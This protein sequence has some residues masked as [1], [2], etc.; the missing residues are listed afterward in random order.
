VAMRWTNEINHAGVPGMLVSDLGRAPGQ[1]NH[2][3]LSRFDMHNTLIAAGPDF[4]KGWTDPVP[5]GNTDIAPTVAAILGIPNDPPMDGRVLTEA[6]RDGPADKD[7]APVLPRIDEQRLTATAPAGEAFWNQYLQVK[8]VNGTVYF[9]EGN[10]GQ[11]PAPIPAPASTP[12][13]NP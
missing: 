6:L 4:R 9:D 1:G 2:T 12:P 7:G 3:S 8:T 13:P 5:S 10:G 11:G